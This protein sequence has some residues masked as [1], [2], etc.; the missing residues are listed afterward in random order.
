MIKFIEKNFAFLAILFSAVALACPQS[1]IWIKPHIPKFLGVIMF[2]M[3]ITLNFSDFKGVWQH[4][5][6]VI[7]GIIMQYTIMPILAVM[8]ALALNLPRE[9]MVGLIIV[10]ACPS[11]TASNV[12]SYMGKANLALSVTLTL[13]TTLLAPLLTPAIIYLILSHKI[14]IPFW[15]MVSS[16]FWIV[17]FPLIDGLIIRHLLYRRIKNIIPVFPS[18]S[19]L[20][21]LVII[22]CVVGLNQKLL[23]TF[24]ALIIF[25]VVLHNGFGLC[26]GYYI[27]KL[28]KAEEA[29]ARTLAFEVGLQNSGLGVTLAAKFFTVA[30]A[31]PSTIFSVWHNI[32]GILLAKWWALD[33]GK[34]LE[35]TPEKLLHN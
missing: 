6:L 21:I 18:I 12:M 16:V 10:G 13:C 23:L 3:G 9:L 26:L 7:T 34:N 4:K 5:R 17:L 11:G 22:A 25:A 35:Q 32:S 14:A 15:S 31:L 2:G 28:L 20:C 30:A 1:F 27:A 19:I 29:E 33:K 8:I 24:P